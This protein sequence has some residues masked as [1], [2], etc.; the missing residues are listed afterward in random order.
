[1][2]N[3]RHLRIAAGAGDPNPAPALATD[4]LAAAFAL[5]AAVDSVGL[6]EVEYHVEV[7]NATD[8]VY[9]KAKALIKARER[10]AT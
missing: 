10:F 6:T 3:T 1:V 4:V 5:V 7:E 8:A 2:V 9:E